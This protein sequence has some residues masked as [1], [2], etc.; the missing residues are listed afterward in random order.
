MRTIEERA[1]SLVYTSADDVRSSL[2]N[3]DVADIPVL[4]H[5]L[6]MLGGR[7][8]VTTKVLLIERRLR[9]LELLSAR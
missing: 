4:R 2:S 1:R 8:N 9:Q 5:A 3:Y 6:E 7:Q